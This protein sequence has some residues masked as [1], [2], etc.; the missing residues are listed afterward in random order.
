MLT[1]SEGRL[2]QLLTACNPAEGCR[3]H[4]CMHGYA[5]TH[6]PTHDAYSPWSDILTSIYMGF[7]QR[8]QHSEQKIRCTRRG[9]SCCCLV[10]RTVWQLCP[11]LDSV[12]PGASCLSPVGRNRLTECECGCEKKDKAVN[13]AICAKQMTFTGELMSTTAL[14]DSACLWTPW[15]TLSQCYAVPWLVSSIFDMKR[16]AQTAPIRHL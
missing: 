11:S 16:L 6:T 5:H 1:L 15:K 2:T 10:S 12:G 4:I 13:R 14:F 9:R 7:S 3:A 8:G